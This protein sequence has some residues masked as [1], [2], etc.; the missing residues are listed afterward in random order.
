MSCNDAKTVMYVV[1]N[2]F[3]IYIPRYLI[4]MKNLTWMLVRI[5][6]AIFSSLLLIAAVPSAGQLI[7]KGGATIATISFPEDEGYDYSKVTGFSLGAAYQFSFDSSAFSLQPEINFV[8]RGAKEVFDTRFVTWY[9][10]ETYVKADYLEIPV[11]VKFQ[12]GKGNIQPFLNA[13]PS[14]SFGIGGK[15]KTQTMEQDPYPT[16]TPVYTNRN[17]KVKYGDNSSTSRDDELYIENRIDYGI[18]FGGGVLI[19]K[20]ILIDL[21]YYHGLHDLYDPD[22]SLPRVLSPGKHR[23]FMFSAGYQFGQR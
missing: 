21:R 1:L 16:G 7:V 17:G 12:L 8:R 3:Y 11:L 10:A 15:F 2:N 5:R 20:K 4:E 13:G 23:V 6:A 18:Q 9:R 19:L 22:D 14:I